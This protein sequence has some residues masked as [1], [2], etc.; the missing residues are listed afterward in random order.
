MGAI[1]KMKII[2]A[3]L[4]LAYF[5]VA[6]LSEAQAPVQTG[7]AKQ[8]F[9]LEIS[10]NLDKDHSNK[11][12]FVN[13]AETTVKAGS[14]IVL[15]IRKTNISDREIDKWTAPGQHSEVRDDGG[16]LLKPRPLDLSRPMASGGEGMLRGTKDVVLQPGESK[17]HDGQL[18]S[19]YDLTQPGTYTVQVSEHISNDPAS[20]V[21]KSNVITITVN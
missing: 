7:N 6:S 4:L 17:I 8:P 1:M 3:V 2:Y 13:S 15:A 21:V 14:M 19:G 20:P 12:D 11:W 9:T 5:S 10:A 18:S 16:N